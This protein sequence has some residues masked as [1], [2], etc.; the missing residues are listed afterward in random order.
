MK[1]LSLLQPWAS[2]IAIGAKKIETRSWATKYRGPLAIHASAKFG[3]HEK[4][5]CGLPGFKQTLI[6]HRLMRESKTQYG[7]YFYEMPLGSIIA[8]CNLV[9]V[10]PVED[11]SGLTTKERAFGDYS[12][13]RYAW[14][15]ED[16]RPLDKPVPAKGKLG[17]WEWAGDAG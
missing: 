9:D 15:L 6:V 7:L 11:I 16:V 17:L 8:I 1:A 4:A 12:P 10:I 5:T 3:K 13:G 2:L 14:V